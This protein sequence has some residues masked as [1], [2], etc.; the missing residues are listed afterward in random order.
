MSQLA[1]KLPDVPTR[2]VLREV[3]LQAEDWSSLPRRLQVGLQTVSPAS[4]KG[5]A[6]RGLAAFCWA[7]PEGG[8]VVPQ[9][10]RKFVRELGLR[11]GDNRR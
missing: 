8:G 2:S 1:L 10:L 7:H 5:R 3:P 6:Y 4:E 11:L 9:G